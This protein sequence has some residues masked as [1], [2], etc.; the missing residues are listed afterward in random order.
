MQNSMNSYYFE[1]SRHLLTNQNCDRI[2]LHGDSVKQLTAHA[3]SAQKKA[4]KKKLLQSP[5][6]YVK[7]HIRRNSST[8]MLIQT[9]RLSIIQLK[10]KPT[11][12]PCASKEMKSPELSITELIPL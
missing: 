1:V 7:M 4:S 2:F 8:N 5:N 3:K 12:Y 9:L 10:R 6:A 11:S